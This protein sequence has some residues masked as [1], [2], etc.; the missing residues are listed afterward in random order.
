[1]AKTDTKTEVKTNAVDLADP[2]TGELT[3]QQTGQLAAQ[4]A[5]IDFSEDAGRGLEGTT[6]D[7][8]AI[9]FVAILQG[10]SPQV[11]DGVEGAR[12]G[13]IMDSVTQEFTEDI[14]FV[15]CAFERRFLEWAPR[16]KGGG[17]KGA[18]DPLEVESGRY[19]EEFIDSKG[20]KRL[21]VKVESKEQGT[22]YNELKDTRTHYVMILKEDGTFKPAVI[23]FSSTQV[24]KSKRLLA[25]IQGNQLRR[26]DGTL[27]TPPSFAFSYNGFS[28]K[29]Q[30]DQGSWF[31][32]SI[33]K[34]G[35]VKS[36]ELYEA[37]K[38]FNKLIGEGAVK[39]QYEDPNTV[40]AAA[41]GEQ[42]GGAASGGREGAF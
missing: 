27:Y 40:D 20:V 1:M 9:P 39:A 25:L 15:P 13:L 16:N 35:A 36:R 28:V 11:V 34:L 5:E 2:K 38:A 17:F 33:G 19:G 18:H 12:P 41:S 3:V 30:N 42:G 14:V 23:S 8:F 4:E 37:C 29:E 31:G 21:G 6:R 24:K 7:D 10:L 22:F 26:A 32:W